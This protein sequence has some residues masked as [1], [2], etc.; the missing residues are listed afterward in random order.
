M[1]PDPIGAIRAIRS[2]NHKKSGRSAA[3]TVSSVGL[4]DRFEK[5]FDLCAGVVAVE[6]GDHVEGDAFGADGLAFAD[7]GATAEAFAVHGADHGEG[8][9]VFLDLTLWKVVHVGDL[10]GGKEHGGGVG[11]G[12]DAGPAT[13][14]GGGIHGGIGGLFGNGDGV[15]VDGA[16]GT[17]GDESAGLDD[18]VEG[19]TV[20][21]EVLNDGKGFGA[22]GLDGDGFTVFEVT[23]V[24]LAGGGLFFRAVGDAVDGEG[25]HAA[26][27]FAAIMV[28][29]EGFFALRD[30]LL[31]EEVEHFEEGGILGDVVELIVLKAALVEGA[32]LSPDA[33]V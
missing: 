23:H 19:G 12:G 30:E 28:K 22:P 33:K 26:D 1:N 21:D 6:L 14:T 11:T 25:T 9:A 18:A 2:F 32:L 13:D 27:A 20:D 4:V 17:G 16:S 5:V 7:V 15:G 10:G 3:S 24:K 29:G 31:A 8:A